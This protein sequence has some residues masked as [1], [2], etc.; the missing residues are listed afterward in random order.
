MQKPSISRVLTRSCT[1]YP[2]FSA[3]TSQDKN[4]PMTGTPASMF[5]RA[6]TMETTQAEIL[7]RKITAITQ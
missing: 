3:P 1:P 5:A 4:A 6:V 7:G 2:E